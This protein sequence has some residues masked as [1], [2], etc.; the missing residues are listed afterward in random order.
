M[1][2]N[3]GTEDEFNVLDIAKKILEKIR[4]DKNLED[5]ITYVEPRSFKEKRYSTTT[6]GA[7]KTLGWKVK[8]SFDEG[9]EKTIQWYK[10]NQDYWIK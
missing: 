6:S 3:I 4:P 1:V 10:Q 8:V 5:V 9:L 2:Y 7:A